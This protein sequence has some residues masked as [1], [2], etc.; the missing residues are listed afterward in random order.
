MLIILKKLERG[1]ILVNKD[2]S[3]E[4]KKSKNSFFGEYKKIVKKMYKPDMELW[5]HTF[6]RVLTILIISGIVLFLVDWTL[7]KGVLN[8]QGVLPS[9]DNET[10][11][12][13][14]KGSIVLLC[15]VAGTG[16]LAQQGGDSGGLTAML[17]SS[18]QYGDVTGSYSKKISKTTYVSSFLLLLLC[19]FSPVIL[20]GGSL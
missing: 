12:W 9:F 10:L 18:V 1:L 14:Y 8:L 11:K 4:K 7:L 6:W 20:G 2:T 17:G 15:I 3:T 16:V 5:W 19:L 13:I